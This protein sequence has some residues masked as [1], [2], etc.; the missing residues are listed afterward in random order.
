MRRV[1]ALFMCLSWIFA[2]RPF[3]STDAD[4]EEKGKVELEVGVLELEFSTEGTFNSPLL[5][6]NFGLGK[7]LELVGEV[8]AHHD[9]KGFLPKDAELSEENLLVKWVIREGALQDREGVSV[10][11]EGGLSFPSGESSGAE[12]TAIFS[13][14]FSDLTWHFNFG[15]RLGRGETGYFAGFILESPEFYRL[16]AVGEWAY[17]KDEE[18]GEAF[19]L[20]GLIYEFKGFSLDF[21]LRRNL[22]QGFYY[23]SAGGTFGF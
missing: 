17:E 5:V 4:V 14:R 7:G 11:L 8:E 18:G 9:F 12:I 19:L 20:V 15:P 23:V 13:G 21:A 16:R 1:L 3:Y 6:V 22:S 10:A 2:Y